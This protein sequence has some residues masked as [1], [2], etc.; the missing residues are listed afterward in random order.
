MGGRVPCEL[1]CSRSVRAGAGAEG[2]AGNVRQ[3]QPSALSEV[4]LARRLTR[5]D[6]QRLRLAI[7]EARIRLKLGDWAGT[8]SVADSLLLSWPVRGPHDAQWLAPLAVLTGRLARARELA[9]Q[10]SP[11]H[12]AFTARGACRR[13]GTGHRCGA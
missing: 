2:A 5:D 13:D 9:R 6:D 8:K 11:E 1:G 10:S 7:A 4:R 12:V 3:G